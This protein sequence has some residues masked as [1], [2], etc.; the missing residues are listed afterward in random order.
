MMKSFCITTQQRMYSSPRQEPEFFSPVHPLVGY[1]TDRL[2]TLVYRKND[3]WAKLIRGC[4]QNRMLCAIG[5]SSP[6]LPLIDLDVKLEPISVKQAQKTYAKYLQH[7]EAWSPGYGSRLLEAVTVSGKGDPRS[8]FYSHPEISDY[9]RNLSDTLANIIYET[10]FVARECS[11]ANAVAIVWMFLDRDQREKCAPLATAINL[12]AEHIQSL[13]NGYQILIHREDANAQPFKPIAS[14]AGLMQV[15]SVDE[16]LFDSLDKTYELAVYFEGQDLDSEE[17]DSII[18]ELSDWSVL[19]IRSL[20]QIG[21]ASYQALTTVPSTPDS[22][23]S[24]FAFLIPGFVLSF[25]SPRNYNRGM[26]GIN[27]F[28]SREDR[29]I[30]V[31]SAFMSPST[32]P[33]HRKET[34]RLKERDCTYPVCYASWTEEQRLW[35]EGYVLSKWVNFLHGLFLDYANAGE[36]D[37][38]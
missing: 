6:G 2:S 30:N 36:G 13:N 27:Y 31:S 21:Q 34:F 12:V 26:S 35:Y 1:K 5:H 8:V 29:L 22:T 4:R 20:Y 7:E 18:G 38:E 19:A 10:A 14:V 23:V 15:R 17:V 16:F 9:A 28:V 25:T 32:F 3:L 24:D 37:F 33:V 11:I